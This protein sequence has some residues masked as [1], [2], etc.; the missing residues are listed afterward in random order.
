MFDRIVLA[1]DGSEHSDRAASL[2][3]ELAKHHSS[4]VLV[5][6]VREKAAVRFGSYDVDLDEAEQDIADE[7]ARKLKDQGISARPE[8]VTDFYGNTA[9]RVARA[10]EEYDANVIV[11]GSRGL[12]DMGGLFL[13][14]VAHKVLHAAPCPVLIVS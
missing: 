5:F 10:A 4:D 7:T 3:S 11:M 14:S 13:G 1:I 2:A 9:K 8:R 6:H 12:S